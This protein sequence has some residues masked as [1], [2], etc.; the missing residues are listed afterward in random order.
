LAALIDDLAAEG[1]LGETLVAALGEFGRTPRV[2]T[3]PGSTQP[4]RDHWAGV[5]SGLFAG[6]GVR[7]GRVLG[8]SDRIGEKINMTLQEISFLIS[9]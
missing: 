2:S 3:L 5:Y 9:C 7:G 1:R 8:R 6:A 4:G